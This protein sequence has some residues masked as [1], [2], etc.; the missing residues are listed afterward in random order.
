[1]N[2]VMSRALDNEG[3][4][5]YPCKVLNRFACPY[6]KKSNNYTM[7]V[8]T[9]KPDVDYLFHLSE[10]AFALELALAKAQEEDSV[11]RIRS[12]ADVYKVLTDR[13]TFEKVLQQGLKDKHKRYK[14]EIVEFLLNMKNRTRVK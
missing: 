14:D 1:M 6:D 3:T 11:F 8:S 5:I 12:A 10:I 13:E 4:S 2:K 9:E 7:D